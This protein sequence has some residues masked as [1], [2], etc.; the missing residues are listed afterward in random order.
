MPHRQDRVMNVR[1]LIC[2]SERVPHSTNRT[3]TI[4]AQGSQAVRGQVAAIR[5]SCA[6]R[7]DNRS[8]L[9]E[10]YIF[11]ER[12]HGWVPLG[13]VHPPTGSRSERCNLAHGVGSA[14]ILHPT[15]GK[16]VSCPAGP[17]RARTRRLLD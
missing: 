12:L 1:R 5:D 9:G 4:M 16:T 6:T 8:N 3:I 11:Q 7:D 17:H 13:I 14:V 2:A 10:A 15:L